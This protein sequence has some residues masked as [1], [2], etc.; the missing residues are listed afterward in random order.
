M[1]SRPELIDATDDTIEDAVKYA[2]PMVLRG[3]I[4]QLTGD[5]S[6]ADVEVTTTVVGFTETQTVARQS[7]IALL[8]SKGAGF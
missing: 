5:E 6:I 1:Q 4:Y 2:D 3:L 8:Q 7:D